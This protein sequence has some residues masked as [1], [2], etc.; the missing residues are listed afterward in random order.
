MRSPPPGRDWTCSPPPAR[1]ARASPVPPACVPL[2][3]ASRPRARPAP[4]TRARRLQA[5][6]AAGA[7]LILFAGG[8]GTARDMAAALGDRVPVIGVPAGVKMH[9]AVYATS[10]RAA[11]DLVLRALDT[12]ARRDRR[13]TAR[14]HGHRR[15]SVPRRCRIGQALRLY[16]GA[17]CA[18]SHPERE[19]GRGQRRPR[20]ARRNRR[21]D[22]RPDGGGANLHPGAGHHH[23]R[24]HASARPAQDTARR[25]PGAGRGARR[26]R[27]ERGRHPPRVLARRRA[28]VPSS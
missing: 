15:G 20:G 6:A 12:A 5:M 21:R 18:R 28:P 26:R 1:W 10:P 8:D 16:A 23:A 22:R 3:W 9:S 19:G 4:R 24:R 27:R 7:R 17:L 25:G 2:P 14:S 11:A 13:A